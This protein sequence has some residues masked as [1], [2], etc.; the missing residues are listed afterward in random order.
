MRVGG[1]SHGAGQEPRIPPSA[2]AHWFIHSC[3][4]SFIRLAFAL[5]PPSAGD[6]GE[7]GGLLPAHGEL[8]S[9]RRPAAAG[10]H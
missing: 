2:P 6:S 7:P 5:L 8:R 10:G 1:G 9:V 4:H 3:F